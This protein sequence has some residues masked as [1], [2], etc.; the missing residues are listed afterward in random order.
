MLS[1]TCANGRD[2]TRRVGAGEGR[3]SERKTSSTGVRAGMLRVRVWRVGD[4][5][6]LGRDIS[7]GAG[8]GDGMALRPLAGND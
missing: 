5:T 1:R 4:M 3:S 7:L 2:L 8:T 6:L